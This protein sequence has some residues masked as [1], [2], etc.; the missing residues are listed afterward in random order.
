MK[1]SG[2]KTTVNRQ[3]SSL[4]ITAFTLVELL[5]V[6][7]II[8]LLISILLPSLSKA[9][10]SANRVKCSSNLRQIGLAMVM[11]TN[12]NKGYFPGGARA[13]VKHL[14]D[15]INWQQPNTFWNLPAGGGPT[16]SVA[17]GLTR[18]LDEG[19][20]VRYMGSHFNAAAWTCPSDSASSHLGF[21]D[22]GTGG[23]SSSS[24]GNAYPHYPYSYTM[25]FLLD[26]NLNASWMGGSMKMA[27]VK[28]SSDTILMLEEGAATVNDG[29]C[30]MANTGG[31]IGPDF[32][33]VIHDKSAKLPDN[34]TGSLTGYDQTAGMKNARAK[35]NVG[36]CD[37]HADYVT[38]EFA[39]S[40]NGRHW[41]PTH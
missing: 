20:I 23:S 30:V 38:R 9:R 2:Q 18:T 31:Q 8:A 41:D 19:A 24:S 25:N 28:H 15:Y 32:L 29:I 26:S 12:D 5:V 21:Y 10:E 7:G 33:S 3:S 36:F 40:P 13:D 27:R 17:S 1:R 39:H 22:P 16:Y 6:I 4:A 14:N 11:Y 34:T 35:G 37:G